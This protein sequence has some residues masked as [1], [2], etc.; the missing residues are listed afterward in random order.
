M[1]PVSIGRKQ[2]PSIEVNRYGKEEIYFPL[3]SM[4]KVR[5]L[6]KGEIEHIISLKKKANDVED[7]EIF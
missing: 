4:K 7:F 1:E 5:D 3:N 6:T 2:Y